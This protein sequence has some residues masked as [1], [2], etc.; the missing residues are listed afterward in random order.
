VEPEL[1]HQVEALC[2]RALE[3]D[4]TGRTEFLEHSCG[5]DDE[6]RREVESLLAYGK[7]AEHFIDSPALEVLGKVV[8]R[9]RE[10][11]DNA[12]KLIG[13]RVSHYLILEKLGAGGM[14]VVYKAKD[15]ELGRFVALKFLSDEL[16]RDRHALERLRREARAASTLNHPNICTIHEIGKHGEQSFI[17]M[18]FLD[19][20][21][22]KHLIAGKALDNETVLSMAIEIADALDA[23]HSQGIVHRDIKP[24]NIFVTKRG[25]AKVLDFGLAKV[26]PM[27]S[28]LRLTRTATSLTGENL[29]NPGSAL[30]TIAYMSPEQAL[31]KPLDERTDLFSLGVVL[32]E[33]ATGKVP[34]GGDSTGT[35]FLNVVQ[36]SPTPPR[37]LNPD[38]PEA[39]QQ[40]ILRCLE[41]EREPRYQHAPEIVADLRRLQSV[42]QVLLPT[43]RPVSRQVKTVASD[44]VRPWKKVAALLL[45]LTVLGVSG[46]L[47]LRLR[48]SHAL[49][50]QDKIVVA[51]I[52]NTTGDAV[53]DGS[54]R[55][56][57]AVS[58]AQ[59]A[60][61]KVVPDRE[62]TATLK[63]MNK[64]VGT[65][66]SREIA[67]EICVRVGG[68]VF[69][70]GTIAQDLGGYQLT[71]EALD[72]SNNH[73]IGTADAIAK[74]PD[75]VVSALGEA[76]GQ[77]RRRMGESL[78]SLQR[79]NKPLPEATTSSL[80]ALREY[81]TAQM[82]T[83]Q[84][85]SAAAI[86]H[87]QR[88]IAI[89]PN[90]AL[91]YYSL[92][93]AYYNSRQMEVGS[94]ADRKAFELRNRVTERE[95]FQIESS[96][97]RNVTGE[98][99]QLIEA[100]ERASETYPDDPVFHTFRGLA[101]AR[102]GQHQNA[103]RSYE[104]ARRLAP[105]KYYP[106]VNL[107][108]EYLFLNKL[109][110]AKIAYAEARKR[111][112]DHEALREN[113][114]YV[115]FLENDEATMA[116]E[117]K[118]AVGRVGYEDR[119]LHLAAETEGYHGRLARSLDIERQAEDKAKR[120]GAKDRVAEYE[121]VAAWRAAEMGKVD[122]ARRLAAKALAASDDQHVR[123]TAAFSLARIGDI[124]TAENTASQLERKYPVDTV[125]QGFVIPTIRALNALSRSDTPKAIAT[126]Q[127]ILPSELASVNPSNLEPTYVRGLAYLKLRKGNEAAT[128]FQK[129]IDHPGNITNF[130][131][132]ALVHLQLAR[133]ET[134]RGNLEQAR[135]EYQD[136]LALW[137]DADPDIPIYK[138]AKAE[139]AKL[140]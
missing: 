50:S 118:A 71:L 134:L 92:A 38:I 16:S 135:R 19:G 138:Q 62:M 140:Q 95:R 25:H 69:I 44:K 6:L 88:V 86:P 115:A 48:R 10:A 87:L 90:F 24:T 57:L 17:V 114:Y 128:E 34:F 84:T 125:M 40:I 112:L 109:D 105:D 136:F 9:E 55:P 39:L 4:E 60:F 80:E 83:Q 108:A 133:T 8:A 30:G 56:A 139:Y 104:N 94:A 126:L 49:V 74:T 110:E 73:A 111:N 131:T 11:T 33:M 120:S 100:S 116:E 63:L 27:T 89:D 53:F 102:A 42:P 107:T 93:S 82:V 47:L 13:S 65:L 51:D 123:A 72:C 64:P 103:A 76:A 79:F 54:L 1:W 98:L 129:I 31:G 68:R 106:Y 77:L 58:L 20:T 22:L 99:P 41:K 81:A 119:M 26:A 32:Y 3:L 29:S 61:F 70:F 43:G 91:A 52:A 7:R 23:A 66:F 45:L 67:R 21:T 96:Y 78:A 122:I 37:E 35:V 85:G 46:V 14:G 15:T 2:N 97:Y 113:R 124:I 132:A 75:H 117:L 130:V 12:T 59:S 36:Q 101:Y 28:S 127:T 5:G 18:E 121:A 137:K